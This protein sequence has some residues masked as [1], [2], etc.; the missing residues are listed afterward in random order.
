MLVWKQ[1][2]TLQFGGFVEH[3]LEC[4]LRVEFLLISVFLNLDQV[5]SVHPECQ[6]HLEM[7]EEEAKCADLLMAQPGTHKG[8]AG[9]V[10]E[11][12]RW[13]PCR[14]TAHPHSANRCFRSPVSSKRKKD[15]FSRF[16]VNF[17]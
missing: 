10:S 16:L 17:R 15:L 13:A 3:L 9:L 5:S 11:V 2:K 7:Q 12:P 6:V 4:L 14:Q 1:L 8:K